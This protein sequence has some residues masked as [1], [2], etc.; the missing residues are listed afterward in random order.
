[1]RGV[2]PA[3]RVPYRVGCYCWLIAGGTTWDVRGAVCLFAG[4]WSCQPSCVCA[5]TTSLLAREHAPP[6][7][8]CNICLCLQSTVLQSCR[9]QLWALLQQAN[10]EHARTLRKLQAAAAG[11]G[12]AA[13]PRGSSSSSMEALAVQGV[14]GYVGHVCG[15]LAACVEAEAQ[16]STAAVG[17]GKGGTPKKR[18]R[19]AA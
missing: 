10:K 19:A 16:S 4:R 2:P 3:N 12:Q 17:G 13:Q 7:S 5:A 11:A 6:T 18:S 8:A 9:K 1:M 14:A 15:A